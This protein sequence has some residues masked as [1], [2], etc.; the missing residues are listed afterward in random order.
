MMAA[1][2]EDKKENLMTTTSA[3][4]KIMDAFNNDNLQSWIAAFMM[5][6]RAQNMA[7]GTLHFYKARLKDFSAYFESV[8]IDRVMQIEPSHIRAFLLLLQEKGHNPGGLHSYYRVIKAFLRWFEFEPENW[9]NP[10]RQIK[11]PKNPVIILD[12]V[13]IDVAQTM[14][15]ICPKIDFFGLRDRAIILC[16]LD[17]GLRASELLAMNIEDVNFITGEIHILKGKGR[18]SRYVFLGSKSRKALR[19]YLKYR[20]DDTEALWLARERTRMEYC[21]LEGVI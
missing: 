15:D 10:I 8:S 1:N 20:P 16:L 13:N 21:G 14:I 18:K 17:T 19:S 2:Q 3:T 5:D 4:N 9:R 7:N 6:R 11:A 12:P